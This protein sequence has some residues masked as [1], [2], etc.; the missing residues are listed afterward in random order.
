MKNYIELKDLEVYQAGRRLS[1]LGW[2]IYSNLDWQAKKILGDHPQLHWCKDE[3]D[4]AKGADAIALLTE[5]KQFRL[6][7]FKPVREFM[8]G[9]ASFDGRNQYKPLDMKSKGFEYM[10]IGIPDS[11]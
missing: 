7:D 11:L 3:F 5:W 4:A 2:E 8:K 6:V 9:N 1:K 10:G